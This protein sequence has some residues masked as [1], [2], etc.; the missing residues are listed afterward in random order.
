MLACPSSLCV[1]PCPP[2]DDGRTS[3]GIQAGVSATLDPETA[4]VASLTARLDVRHADARRAFSGGA[5]PSIVQTSP[6]VVRVMV[7]EVMQDVVL[8]LPI[9]G[10]QHKARLARRS[11]YI[12]VNPSCHREDIG[13]HLQLQLR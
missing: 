3:I 7:G 8:P 13:S 1:K 6:C 12:E 5:M 2:S 10:G 9:E 11:S 4:S